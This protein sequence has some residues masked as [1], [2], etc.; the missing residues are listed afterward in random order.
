MTGDLR[1]D[2]ERLWASH[3]ELATFTEPGRPHTRRPF[4]ALHRDGR[5]WLRQ[6]FTDAGLDVSVDAGGNL[7]GRL[8]GADCPQQVIMTGSH[9]DTV[10]AGGRFDG[11]SG[12]LT[13]LEIARVFNDRGHRP[14][15]GFE[16]VDFLSEEPSDFG[17]SC[18][19]SRA[20][21]GLLSQDM[22]AASDPSGQPL[23]DA[24][25][26]IGGASS[27]LGSPL[28]PQG[29]IKAF[30]E[31]HIEQGKV[32][33]ETGTDI[34]VVT[35]I[36]GIRRIG[37]VVGGRADHA[38]TTPMDLRTD[39]LAGAARLVADVQTTARRMADEGNGYIVATV[40]QLTVH[41][42]GTNVVPDRVDFTIDLRADRR[43]LIEAFSDEFRSGA[44]A[45]I[46]DLGTSVET[47][48]Q[49]DGVPTD[50]DD[51]LQA[52]I[53]DACQRLGYSY[54]RMPSGAGHD[55]VYLAKL[56]PAGMV[57]IPC[58]EGRSHCPEEWTTSGQLE[59][60]ANVMLQAILAVDQT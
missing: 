38:G 26:D 12:V 41:P 55:A 27:S 39:A 16:V 59:T 50:C 23:R 60:G 13:G 52:T 8:Q 47:T 40:G 2:A 17:V 6:Q 11:I 3:M 57:F 32:L 18:V 25:D 7:G 35:N 36:V 5:A 53:D 49:T 51:G 37:V 28:R 4:S 42:G 31:L 45:R 56:A 10:P 29:A 1:V 19:G 20:I 22:L 46:A 9:S 44:E 33:E 30:L 14:R 15:Y 58:R 43:S 21:A 54:R 34:G 24:I 48:I